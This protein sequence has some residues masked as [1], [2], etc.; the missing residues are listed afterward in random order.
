MLPAWDYPLC[1]TRK[2][3]PKAILQI[4]YWPSLYGQDGWISALFFLNA[5]LW[6]ETLSHIF[7]CLKHS[8]SHG[9]HVCLVMISTPT[10]HRL[11]SPQENEFCS[12]GGIGQESNY[13]KL[14]KENKSLH[15]H[16]PLCKKVLF[17]VL[18][19][20]TIP[21]QIHTKADNMSFAFKYLPFTTYNAEK[22]DCYESCE[23][24]DSPCEGFVGI[25]CVQYPWCLHCIPVHR[26]HSFQQRSQISSFSIYKITS[27][28]VYHCT[29]SW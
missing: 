6:T 19:M 24:I 5:G 8:C 29:W 26:L 3:P 25:T 27:L 7:I 1:P 9:V 17:Q 14:Y 11:L 10:L 4:L 23:K 2:I 13:T 18:K 16:P 21:C 22:H 20:R 28:Q 15:S 12:P